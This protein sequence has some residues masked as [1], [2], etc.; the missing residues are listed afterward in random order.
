VVPN[1]RGRSGISVALGIDVR[2]PRRGDRNSRI[3]TELDSGKASTTWGRS[4]ERQLSHPPRT[5]PQGKIIYTGM[6]LTLPK[7]EDSSMKFL[8]LA[9]PA[10]LIAVTS[11][12]ASADNWR[13]VDQIPRC[14][15]W[16]GHWLAHYA[17]IPCWAGALN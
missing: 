5:I 16:V 13:L 14:Q 6:N 17:N 10:L 12:S 7:R 9:V 15:M 8:K 1:A 2:A 11:S 4:I 3:K